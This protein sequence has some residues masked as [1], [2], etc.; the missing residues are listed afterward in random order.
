MLLLEYLEKKFPA[1]TRTTLKR[2]VEARRVTINGRPAS[3]LKQAVGAGDKVEVRDRPKA[4]GTSESRKPRERGGATVALKILHE[5][6]DV[7]V[8]AKP[9]G[10]LTST[11]ER[12]RRPTVAAKLREYLEETRP[13][14]R[15]G[16]IHRL[17]R[18]ASGLIVFIKNAKAYHNLK[19]QFY[20][21]TV[22][23]IYTAVV[24]GLPAPTVGEIENLLFELPTGQVVQISDK[25]KGQIA[26]TEYGVLASLDI[27]NSRRRQ[28]PIEMPLHD[29]PAQP[30]A[31]RALLRVKLQT[32]RKHQIRAHFASR[33]TPIVGDPLYGPDPEP[34]SP[35]LLAA[36]A[37]AFDHPATGERMRFEI[38]APEGIRAMF[39]EACK[40]A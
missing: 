34:V 28:P 11:N 29:T 16:V 27:P 15:L 31:Y 32:G 38:E 25:S 19:R 18:D 33:K 24:E 9:P 6:E 39:P 30:L 13:E 5:D 37:L 3:R 8:L 17:D 26:V 20:P 40:P 22:D 4:K 14:S 7:I 2:M 1:S 35:L 10:L 36:T 12:E 23:R 21:H